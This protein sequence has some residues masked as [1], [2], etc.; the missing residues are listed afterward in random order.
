MLPTHCQTVKT[1]WVLTEN[2]SRNQA[3]NFHSTRC[4]LHS[5]FLLRGALEFCSGCTQA[6][7]RIQLSDDLCLLLWCIIWWK[8]WLVVRVR[9]SAGLLF[10]VWIYMKTRVRVLEDQGSLMHAESRGWPGWSWSKRQAA[11][12]RSAEDQSGSW[13][14]STT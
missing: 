8:W 9:T 12:A 11:G 2:E 4:R 10:P 3:D 5:A 14:L 7:S 13:P 6:R 1:G